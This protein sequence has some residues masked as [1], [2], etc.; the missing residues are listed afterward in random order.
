MDFLVVRSIADIGYRK[1]KWLYTF[2]IF[3]TKVINQPVP[4]AALYKEWVCGRSPTEIVG[5][6]LVGGV[7][8]CLLWVL[9]VV[10]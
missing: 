1:L 9:C 4:V 10:R 3:V 7:Y 8:I 2:V 5:L 6:N